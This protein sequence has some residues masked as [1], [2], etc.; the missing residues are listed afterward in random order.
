MMAICGRHQATAH[1]AR[2]SHIAVNAFCGVVAYKLVPT[3]FL[4][5]IDE[6]AFVLDYF[7]PGGT[8]LVETD[9]QVH[10]AEEILLATPEVEGISRRTGAEL[11]LFATE[12]NTGDLVVRLKPEGERDRSSEEVIN[13]VRTKI[14]ADVKEAASDPE[15]VKRLTATAQIVAP[16]DAKEFAA[17]IAEQ[18]EQVAAVAKLFGNK[19][20][21]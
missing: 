5:E 6:G 7:T 19:P 21:Q 18:R 8:A 13:E 17:S 9:R 1:T 2:Q 14:A 10:I 16:G 3:G 11:G 12:Q 20:V 15:I 4:P